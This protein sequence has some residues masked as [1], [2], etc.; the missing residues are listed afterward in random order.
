MLHIEATCQLDERETVARFGCGTVSTRC[1]DGED[2]VG[3][4]R[5]I[6]QAFRII[7]VCPCETRT[8]QAERTRDGMIQRARERAHLMCALQQRVGD[9]AA[10]PAGGTDNEHIQF[11]R[12]HDGQTAALASED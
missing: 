2:R 7:E 8:A 9:S 5:Y 10:L 4:A 1:G 12:S 11:R 6:L 3:A